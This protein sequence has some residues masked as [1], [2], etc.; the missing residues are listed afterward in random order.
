MIFDTFDRP[1]PGEFFCVVSDHD[2]RPLRYLSDVKQQGAPL[3]L[4]YVETGPDV[5]H[6]CVGRAAEAE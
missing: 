6:V 5:L 3:T 1:G 2:P 4:E